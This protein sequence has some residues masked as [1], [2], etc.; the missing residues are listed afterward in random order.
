VF[1][2]HTENGI[3]LGERV[4]FIELGDTKGGGS[5]ELNMVLERS[6]WG[7]KSCGAVV[8]LSCLPLGTLK[9]FVS[10]NFISAEENETLLDI[11]TITLMSPSIF[12]GILFHLCSGIKNYS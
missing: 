12:N 3:V 11:V 2:K 8:T 1:V 5:G 6:E 7:E 10:L 9:A 4:G